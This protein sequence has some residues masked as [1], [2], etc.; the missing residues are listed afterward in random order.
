[1]PL[2]DVGIAGER[3]ARHTAPVAKVA[4]AHSEG[5]EELLSRRLHRVGGREFRFDGERY[6]DCPRRCSIIHL[7]GP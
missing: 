4:D 2:G 5:E 1:V 6:H 3:L 7:V